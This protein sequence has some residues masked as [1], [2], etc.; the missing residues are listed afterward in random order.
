VNSYKGVAVSYGRSFL[1]NRQKLERLHFKIERLISGKLD[2]PT[3]KTQPSTHGTTPQNLNN[4]NTSKNGSGGSGG[5]HNPEQNATPNSEGS[6]PPT[7]NS[8]TVSQNSSH[9][10]FLVQSM[11][12]FVYDMND[13]F[14]ALDAWDKSNRIQPATLTS[15]PHHVLCVQPLDFIDYVSKE[16][17]KIEENFPT[18]ITTTTTSSSSPTPTKHNL[19]SS[20]KFE[21]PLRQ[22]GEKNTSNEK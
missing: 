8:G 20:K 11:K 6:S 2:P 5:S 9:Y 22:S 12:P 10:S 21:K 17:Q 19:R 13:L 4:T 18:T 7:P 14:K 3:S 1:L 16:L 15:Y